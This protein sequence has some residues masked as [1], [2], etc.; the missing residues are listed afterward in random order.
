MLIL[1]NLMENLLGVICTDIV[2]FCRLSALEFAGFAVG[3]LNA[4]F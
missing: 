4:N 3:L 1:H 2:D